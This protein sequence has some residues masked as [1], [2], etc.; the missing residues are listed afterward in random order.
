MTESSTLNEKDA[1]L[2]ISGA[3]FDCD[4]E[5]F[6]YVKEVHGGYFKLD[7][8]MARD[9]WLSAGYV[10]ETKGNDVY[11]SISRDEAEEHKLSAPGI[12]QEAAS[13]D[14]LIDND[15]ALRQRERMEAELA[16]QNAQL[17][18][19]AGRIP[20]TAAEVGANDVPADNLR[21]NPDIGRGPV[22]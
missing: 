18:R 17:D 15:T 11:L 10:R 21:V 12:E 8:P 3:I 4:G 7:L 9:I 13:V 14:H 2:P 19:D 5:Q 16:A 22:V 1:P 6:A 20:G